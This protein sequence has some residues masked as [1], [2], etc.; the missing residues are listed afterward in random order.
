MTTSSYIKSIPVSLDS[1]PKSGTELNGYLTNVIN[2]AHSLINTLVSPPREPWNLNFKKSNKFGEVEVSSRNHQIPEG[3]EYWFARRS[4]HEVESEEG[5]SKGTL[6]WDDF[7]N[8]LFHDH[9]ENEREYGPSVSRVDKL[10]VEWG[11][12]DVA[13]A[14]W[15]ITQ[16]NGYAIHHHLPWPLNPRVF[17]VLLVLASA[18]DTKEFMAIS[19]PI[20]LTLDTKGRNVETEESVTVIGARDTVGQYVAVERVA[21]R[22]PETS[23]RKAEV[24]WSMATASDAAGNIPMAMQRRVIGGSIFKDVEAFLLYVFK[25]KAGGAS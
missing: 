5:S 19:I 16:I 6:Q 8:L 10:D 11:L 23:S 3:T 25:K 17:P 14:G 24:A 21:F 9:F 7:K 20:K 2:E 15:N 4:L 22:E 13:V 18:I 12:S 1:I